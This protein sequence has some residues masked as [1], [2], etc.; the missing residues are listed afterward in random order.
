MLRE[1]QHRQKTGTASDTQ[2]RARP[3]SRMTDRER[4]R[5]GDRALAADRLTT[6][7]AD[8]AYAHYMSV[9]ELD[10]DARWGPGGHRPHRSSATQIWHGWPTA[11]GN[12][13]LRGCMSDVDSR[14]DAAMPVC[15]RVAVSSTRW[16]PCPPVPVASGSGNRRRH[17][18]NEDKLWE[19]EGTSVTSTGPGRYRQYRQ[20]F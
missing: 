20:G 14:Y 18:K 6:P 10:P 13:A 9:I 8:N 17:R 16:K 19:F 1:R 2:W 7:A 11:N 3:I 12:T 5:A 4:M 15:W